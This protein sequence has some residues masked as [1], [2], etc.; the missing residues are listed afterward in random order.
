MNDLPRISIVTSSYNQGPFIR[1]TIESVLAQDYPNLEHIVVDGLSK[2]ETP[3]ILA[4]YPHL[5][6]IREK[7]SGQAE[8]INKGFRLATGQI[9]G[10]LNSDDTFEPGALHRVAREID[11]SRGRHIVMGRCRFIDEHDRFIGIE[12]PSAFESHRRVLEIWKGYT[13]PQPAVF[14]TP[15]V[16]QRSGPLDEQ[17][18]LV[19]DYDLF[20]RFSRDYPFRRFDQIVAN[21]RLHT[22]S[23]TQGVDDATRLRDSIRVSRRYWPSAWTPTGAA[24][25][26][27]HFRHVLDRRGRAYRL[28]LVG[29]RHWQARNRV[30]AAPY[31]V[32]GALL[33]PEVAFHALAGPVARRS[34]GK[35][36]ASLGRVRRML[37]KPELSPHTQAWFGFH[38]LHEDMWA[39]PLLERD[40]EVAGDPSGGRLLLAGDTL[41]EA[42]P[43][44]LVLEVSIGETLRDQICLEAT[45]RGFSR[46]LSL[47]RLRPGRYRLII[48]ANGFVVPHDRWGNGDYRPLSYRLTACAVS[49]AAAPSR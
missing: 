28:L 47:D 12:H 39:G 26:A 2:D 42:L 15:E 40:L 43:R 9:F 4:E 23:K 41:P 19:L 3:Q 14:W 32:S 20:C 27:S 22:Q 6:V 11:P 1:R 29:R 16:W 21:Y 13:I 24:I 5:R 37:A 34:G 36:L 25:R 30:A 48:K 18:Q 35:A 10:F 46:E 17:E 45:E 33:G 44:P 8:A 31:F 49:E 38:E 7:D